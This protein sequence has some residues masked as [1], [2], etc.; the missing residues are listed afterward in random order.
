M[1]SVFEFFEYLQKQFAQFLAF[2]R[3]VKL[4]AMGTR[5]YPRCSPLDTR[6]T[7]KWRGDAQR[8]SQF[9][10][11][12]NY[13]KLSESIS[14]CRG[15][16]PLESLPLISVPVLLEVRVAVSRAAV[17]AAASAVAGWPG[18]MGVQR[19]GM[20]VSRNRQGGVNEVLKTRG[21]T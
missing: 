12:T 11:T 4:G 8:L 15:R 17:A 9:L 20:G 16:L 7:L 6:W 18:R 21:E 5:R 13:E 1:E 3:R 19:S 14:L 10:R 2:C